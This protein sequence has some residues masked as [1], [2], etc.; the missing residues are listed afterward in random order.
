MQR[1]P[2]SPGDP[3]AAPPPVH[4]AKAPWGWDLVGAQE[5]SVHRLNHGACV[6]GAGAERGAD[7]DLGQ[8]GCIPLPPSLPPPM[9][10]GLG[11]PPGCGMLVLVIPWYSFPPRP[12]APHPAASAP[13]PVYTVWLS[14][15]SPLPLHVT[16]LS[17][18]SVCAVP[19]LPHPL[20]QTVKLPSE[21]APCNLLVQRR[22]D[23]H[24]GAKL[25]QGLGGSSSCTLRPWGARGWLP[26]HKL[27]RLGRKEG[28]A[29][30]GGC[31]G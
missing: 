25:R 11:A 17:A 5:G 12:S 28:R 10:E 13:S 4:C 23:L 27:Q 18:P 22:R 14:S 19:P 30:P 1:A 3:C 20:T 21:I 16:F 31:C 7:G 9:H 6:L 24:G 2:T 26:A 29:E 15:V 8:Q